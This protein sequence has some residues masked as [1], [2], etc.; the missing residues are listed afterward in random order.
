MVG[1]VKVSHPAEGL[2]N[3][4]AISLPLEQSEKDLQGSTFSFFQSTSILVLKPWGPWELDYNWCITK[5]PLVFKEV[6]TNET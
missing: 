5:Y 6:N 3:Q 1:I 2:Q 4:H